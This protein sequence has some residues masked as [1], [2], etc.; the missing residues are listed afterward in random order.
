MATRLP[1][2]TAHV[3]Y[4][5]QYRRCRRSGCG[6]CTKDK[7]GHG[8]YW[9]AY[10]REDGK[11]RSR[12]LGKTMP[13]GAPGAK[14]PDPIDAAPPFSALRVRTLGGLV[15]WRSSDLIP[16]ARW[17]RRAVRDLFTCL[18]SA[19]GQRLHREQIGELLW[20]DDPRATRKLN[21]TVHV[22]RRLLDGPEAD[23]SAVQV[24]GDILVLEP[25]GEPQLDGD[26]LDAVA[27][28][29]SAR[30]ALAGK[31][32]DICRAALALYGG[33]YLPDDPYAE[34]VAARRETLRGLYQETL[35]HLANLSGTA[36]DLEEA[37][38]CLRSL[39]KEDPCRED[40]AAALIGML[41]AVGRRV[42]ALRVYQELA[43]S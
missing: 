10:W 33:P 6:Q 14:E 41:A 18:L 5:R 12:Y 42:E 24:V 40:A 29:R 27:Y 13:A 8:P 36:G 37:E 17:N 7:P 23:T 35:R 34:W 38:H 4:S 30:A 28:E 2:D 32:R 11:L 19:P 22:L 39:L 16:A 43:A 20:P 9:F 15:V 3:T 1:P 21:D 31:D 26:W 25:V